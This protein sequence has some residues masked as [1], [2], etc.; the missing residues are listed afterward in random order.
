ME[1]DFAINEPFFITFS[2]IK[3]KVRLRAVH[4]GMRDLIPEDAQHAISGTFVSSNSNS[5]VLV[6]IP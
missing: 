6:P 2:I 4:P 1:I 5:Q 3:A